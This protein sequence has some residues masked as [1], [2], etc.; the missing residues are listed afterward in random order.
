MAVGA[1]ASDQVRPVRIAGAVPGDSFDPHNN[2]GT[3][4]ALF[5]AVS[6]RGL[7]VRR[8]DVAIS[9]SQR[10]RLAAS[11]FHPARR[12]WRERF[13]RAVYEAQ[14]RNC[15]RLLDGDRESNVILQLFRGFQARGL[16]YW[17]LLDTTDALRRAA[18]LASPFAA[19][20][21]GPATEQAL[22]RGAEHI[23]VMAS[24]PKAS[25]VRDY[26]VA[27]D[28]ITVVGAGV[29]IEYPERLA[30]LGEI[31]RYRQRT[32]LFVGRDFE[33]KGGPELLE[34]FAEARSAVPDARLV[35][36]G[37]ELERDPPGVE[38]RGEVL[39]REEVRRS[40]EQAAAFCLPSRFEP[41]GM[42]VMEAMA[43]GLPVVGTRVGGIP[44]AIEDGATGILVDQGDRRA[45]RDALLRLIGDPE[46]AARMGRNGRRWI[47]SERNWDAVVDRML[48]A[49]SGHGA[50]ASSR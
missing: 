39:D 34:A 7:L 32:V 11:T 37:V 10:Y 42:S 18:G 47:D 49:V 43:F 46:E 31:V 1:G 36:L 28:T 38:S 44:E 5:A 45:L 2:S 4:A 23:F 27:A 8:L 40:Y 17:L 13:R 20:A 24:E 33:R 48:A 41:T 50:R 6:R 14:S 25:L 21:L 9:R 15:A 26:G 30:A 12:R 22:Y 3:A 29:N 19:G 35:I 16:P